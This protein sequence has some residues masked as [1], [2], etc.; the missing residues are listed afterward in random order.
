MKNKV[1]FN[2]T[3]IILSIT[4]YIITTASSLV[5]VQPLALTKKS[6]NKYSDEFTPD[7]ANYLLYL[8]P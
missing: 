8:N 3:A 6:S 4:M 7:K 5:L 2:K 1:I